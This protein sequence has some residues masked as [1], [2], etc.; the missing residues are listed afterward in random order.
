[1]VSTRTKVGRRTT[2]L[3]TIAST[4]QQL[5]LRAGD[6]LTLLTDERFLFRVEDIGRRSLLR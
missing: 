5:S 6:K 1:V 4:Q 3:Q 2:T